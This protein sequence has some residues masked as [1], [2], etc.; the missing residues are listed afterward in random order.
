MGA[1][2]SFP[3]GAMDTAT[4]NKFHHIS[5]LLSFSL[6]YAEYTR[7]THQSVR[8]TQQTFTEGK[9]WKDEPRSPA[10]QADSVLSET[11]GKLS[12]YIVNLINNQETDN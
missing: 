3:P 10:L 5:Q 4:K 8:E 6:I 7:N 9:T 11:P 2:F 1:A 12:Q